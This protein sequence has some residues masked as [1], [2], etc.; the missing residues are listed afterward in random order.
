LSLEI[1]DQSRD[2][3]D[4]DAAAENANHHNEDRYRD[5]HAIEDAEI[6]FG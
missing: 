1:K 2:E 4:E 3:E 5:S 6:W